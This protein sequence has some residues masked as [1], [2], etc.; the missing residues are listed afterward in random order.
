MR[1]KSLNRESIEREQ[2][3]LFFKEGSGEILDGCASVPL[4]QKGI[5][6]LSNK[7][8]MEVNMLSKEIPHDQWIRFFDDFSK[9]HEGWIVNWEVLDAKLGDQ[10]KTTRLPLIGISAD[11]K[12]KPRIDVMVG[13]RPDAH[14]TQIIDTPKR[15]WFKQP[16]QPG[17]EAIEVESADGTMTLVTFWHFDPE[18]K[19][20]LLPPKE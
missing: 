13:G 19:E 6:P 3:P 7:P 15:V 8:T 11:T 5:E 16:D 4:F 1:R 18:Q 20:H 9:Q 10:E 14:V 12:G 2:F 17:H